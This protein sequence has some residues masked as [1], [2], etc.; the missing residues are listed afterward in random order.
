MKSGKTMRNMLY[1]ILMIVTFCYLNGYSQ[2]VEQKNAP[3]MKINQTDEKN[4]NVSSRQMIAVQPD[5]T[6]AMSCLKYEE[7]FGHGYGEQFK[8]AKK[9]D[10]YRHEAKDYIDY[11]SPHA[12]PYR[13]SFKTK[14]FEPF[15]G[16]VDNHLWFESLESPALL[17]QDESL[18][19]ELIGKEMLDFKTGGKTEK[20]ERIKIKVT[21]ET[22]VGGDYDKAEGFLYVAPELKNLVVKTELIFP[23]AGQICTLKNIS[24]G[25]PANLFK[26]FADYRRA[27]VGKINQNHL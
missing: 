4:E 14:K 17:A 20:R 2:T 11:F 3:E 8:S 12:P 18:K 25:A 1:L 19:I 26:Q 15:T 13:Y 22:E 7:T 5:F 10:F 24:F 6:A 16:D 23:T 27:E 21:G 9:G